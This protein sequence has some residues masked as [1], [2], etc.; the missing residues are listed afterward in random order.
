MSKMASTWDSPTC[1]LLQRRRSPSA[2]WLRWR[3]STRWRWRW[4]GG[5]P[6]SSWR[7]PW[8]SARRLRTSPPRCRPPWGRSSA[9]RRR[10]RGR[11]P[12]RPPPPGTSHEPTALTTPPSSEDKIVMTSFFFPT[13]AYKWGHNGS[14]SEPTSLQVLIVRD[15]AT[16]AL[17]V[18]WHVSGTGWRPWNAVAHVALCLSWPEKS[19]P[20]PHTSCRIIGTSPRFSSNPVIACTCD[21][22]CYGNG[23]KQPQ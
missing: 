22:S 17:E 14:M 20:S 11:P 18:V 12:S 15:R 9:S 16:T 23:G 7:R 13:H 3:R 5:A 1:L 4:T 8:R 21:S 6:W 10:S 2:K 19:P